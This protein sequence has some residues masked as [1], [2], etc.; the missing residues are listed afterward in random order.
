LKHN[1]EI[2]GIFASIA[3]DSDT[4]RIIVFAIDSKYQKRGFGKTCWNIFT[5]EIIQ[6]S[7]NKIQL[8]VKSTNINAIK[9]YEQKGMKIYGE[10]SNYYRDEIGYLML[11]TC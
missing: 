9:F 4:V 2:V 8:E 7:Y 6:N 1:N 10:I 3:L 5:S 11:G